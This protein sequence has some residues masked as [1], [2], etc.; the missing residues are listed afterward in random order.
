MLTPAPPPALPRL[1]LGARGR[2]LLARWWISRKVNTLSDTGLWRLV[3]GT[4]VFIGILA[5]GI[6]GLA[7]IGVT[8]VLD[9]IAGR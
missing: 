1:P 3:T 7:L 6:V 4:A 5:L 8:R 2:L 9:I